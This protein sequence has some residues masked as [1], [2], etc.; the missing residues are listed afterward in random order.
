MS[1][2]DIWDGPSHVEDGP[3]KAHIVS[4]DLGRRNFPIVCGVVFDD[5]SELAWSF[6]AR[7][8]ETRLDCG[9][10]RSYRGWAAEWRRQVRGENID[11][12]AERL[13][14][15]G[16]LRPHMPDGIRASYYARLRRDQSLAIDYLT[17]QMLERRNA[18]IRRLEAGEEEAREL[19][20][21][22]P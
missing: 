6:S 11:A 22:H 3:W 16:E 20:R 5:G 17:P 15:R 18:E 8:G 14:W 21:L 9:L 10:N 4:V 13:A 19:A 12:D 2:R 1:E 7:D